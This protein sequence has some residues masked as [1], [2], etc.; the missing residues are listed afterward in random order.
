MTMIAT[1]VNAGARGFN[2][3]GKAPAIRIAGG[4]SWPGDGAHVEGC[5]LPAPC[6][7]AA[8]ESPIDAI[9]ACVGAGDLH[10][11]E[12][13][14]HEQG[15]A[16]QRPDKGALMQAVQIKNHKRADPPQREREEDRQSIGRHGRSP[17]RPAPC[18]FR[19]ASHWAGWAGNRAARKSRR[20]P[21]CTAA[22]SRRR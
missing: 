9:H 8:G 13:K 16:C 1:S 4:S 6:R 20:R 3:S 18:G 17:T 5:D 14:A 15:G 19:R 22:F 21:G 11:H 12:R 10:A 2:E 7:Q